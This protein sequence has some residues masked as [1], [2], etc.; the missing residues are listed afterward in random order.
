MFCNILGGLITSGQM[1]TTPPHMKKARFSSGSPSAGEWQSPSPELE[2]DSE[3]MILRHNWRTFSDSAY[4]GG[5]E[6]RELCVLIVDTPQFQR[7]RK[8]K[9]VGLLC[10]VSKRV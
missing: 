5:I 10:Y 4:P 1:A 2:K 7:L 8:V 9:Q 6:I 3:D